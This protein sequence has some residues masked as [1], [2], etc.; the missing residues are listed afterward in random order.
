MSNPDLAAIKRRFKAT[1]RMMTPWARTKNINTDTFERYMNGGYAPK[2]ASRVVP[3]IEEALK[4]DG[5]WV[6]KKPSKRKT[7]SL[8]V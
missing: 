4:A 8:A 6:E 3:K 5:L 1:G 7:A 2:K